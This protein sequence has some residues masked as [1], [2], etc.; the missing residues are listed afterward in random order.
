[1]TLQAKGDR[2]FEIKPGFVSAG[3]PDEARLAEVIAAGARI[4]SLRGPSEDP[5]DEPGQVSAAGADFFRLP[6]GPDSFLDESWR[7]QM[8]AL[9]KELDAHTGPVYFHCG[10]ANRTGAAYALYAHH[11]DG[12]S[13]DAA[14]AEGQRAGM[15]RL[16][17]RVRQVLGAD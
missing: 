17:A 13:V 9:V 1:M 10:S 16:E 3:Q 2:E 8:L 7:G 15:T 12:L 4:V 6:T 14:V 5:Y 11:R